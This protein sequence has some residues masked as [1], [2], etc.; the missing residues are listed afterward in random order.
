VNK[1]TGQQFNFNTKGDNG[2]GDGVRYAAMQ[3]LAYMG[4]AAKF[5]VE[6]KCPDLTGV[7]EEV[8]S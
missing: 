1:R 6:D 3:S 5:N 4:K 8:S 2:A 7:E